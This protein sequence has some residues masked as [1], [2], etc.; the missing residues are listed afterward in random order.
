MNLKELN[1]QEVILIEGGRFWCTEYN[2]QNYRNGLKKIID[3]NNNSIKGIATNSNNKSVLLL[4]IISKSKPKIMRSLGIESLLNNY[5]IN[6]IYNS[7]D[8]TKMD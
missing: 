7:T 6:S 8:I 5:N 3:K 1:T 2:F 4:E